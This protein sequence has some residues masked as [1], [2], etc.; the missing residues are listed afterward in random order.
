MLLQG[1]VHY[2]MGDYQGA[3][4]I[5]NQVGLDRLNVDNVSIRKL[6]I[7]GE[8]F[9]IKGLSTFESNTVSLSFLMQFVGY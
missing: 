1:K 3:L 7:V 2:A 6:K 8:A 4:A 5:F 9:A